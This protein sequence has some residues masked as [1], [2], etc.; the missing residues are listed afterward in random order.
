MGQPYGAG[1]RGRRCYP[2]TVAAPAPSEH[3]ELPATREALHRVAEE[4]L[5]AR[6]FEATGNEI[7]LTVRGDAVATPDLPGGGWL[8]DQQARAGQPDPA[9]AGEAGPTA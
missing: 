8:G 2:R 7:A 6:R 1:G 3:P 9:A 5:S 4:V